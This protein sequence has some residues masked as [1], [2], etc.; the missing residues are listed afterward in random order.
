MSPSSSSQIARAEGLRAL[1]LAG[2]LS[3]HLCG[4]PA[5]AQGAAEQGS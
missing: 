1:A 2:E 3:L 4:T 5:A